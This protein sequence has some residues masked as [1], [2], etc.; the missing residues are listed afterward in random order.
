[1]RGIAQGAPS[2][3]GFNRVFWSGLE[4]FRKRSLA[5][6]VVLANFLSTFTVVLVDLNCSERTSCCRQNH[7]T[8]LSSPASSGGSCDTTR[9]P[10]LTYQRSG[11]S[12]YLGQ[13]VREFGTDFVL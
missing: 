8:C 7:C 2:A 5:I 11:R 6:E 9:S 10:A 12:V 4:V 3:E 13:I 1:M